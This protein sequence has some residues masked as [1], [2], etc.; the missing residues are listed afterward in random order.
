MRVR[1]LQQRLDDEQWE[2]HGY[3]YERED[4]RASFRYNTLVWGRIGSD[5]NAK[6]K[7][8]G[9]NLEAVPTVIPTGDQLRWLEIE[10]IAGDPEEIKA[11]LDEAC[12]IPRPQKVATAKAQAA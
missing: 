1:R 9:T 7:K 6:L 8:N 10:E 4:G 12:Q 3:V 11:R 2:D 5:Y